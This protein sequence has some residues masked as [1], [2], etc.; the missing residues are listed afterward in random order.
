MLSTNIL[1]HTHELSVII[2]RQVALFGIV[3]HPLNIAYNLTQF[4]QQDRIA[5]R[6]DST[7]S[8][9]KNPHFVKLFLVCRQFFLWTENMFPIQFTRRFE[10]S[11][12]NLYII[13]V[14]CI[15]RWTHKKRLRLFGY[16]VEIFPDYS[17][18][19]FVCTFILCVQSV[20]SKKI[21][22]RKKKYL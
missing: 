16:L 8:T 2:V 13:C 11:L 20:H 22:F 4:N 12:N 5:K 6:S 1:I 15:N 7:N 9:S 10:P 21:T 3:P 19:R 14:R 17:F 18:L